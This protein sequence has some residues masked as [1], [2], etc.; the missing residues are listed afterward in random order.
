VQADAR[1]SFSEEETGLQSQRPAYITG[2]SRTADGFADFTFSP[3]EWLSLKGTLQGGILSATLTG[4]DPRPADEYRI[5]PVLAATA[6]F[7]SV[8]LGLSTEY[9]Y[10]WAEIQH[11]PLP[12]VHRARVGLSLGW[13]LPASLLLEGSAAFFWS[14]EARSLL[15]FPFE[16][17]FSG[18]PV[19]YLTFRLG[20]GYRVRPYDLKDLLEQSPLL[21][22]APVADDRGWFGEARVQIAPVR[23][24]SVSAALSFMASEAMP[25]ALAVNGALTQD[26]VTGLFL[27]QHIPAN[28]LSSD[29]SLRWNA[30]PGLTLVAGWKH[31]FRDFL[32]LD[33]P[34]FLPVDDITFEGIGIAPD[35]SFGGNL[36]AALRTGTA[37]TLQLPDV[38]LGGFL[39]VSE[40]VRLQLDI[41]DLLQPAQGARYGLY[42][43]IEP[44]FR[45]T[46]KVRMSF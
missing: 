34:S 15:P 45:V 18:T 13:D 33:S 21:L 4:A 29:V 40:G 42:P 32:F 31:E 39:R 28:R 37:P 44:G 23:S 5:S 38:T 24:L 6:H 25:D 35:G 20:F 10:R 3:L 16:L 12:D 11:V 46:G 17:A 8:R 26:P 1:G 36:S 9:S 2:L 43:Y 22:P 19:D 30:V 27:P 14:T 7:E 41:E